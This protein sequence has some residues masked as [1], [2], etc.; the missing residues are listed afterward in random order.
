MGLINW[1]K[2]KVFYNEQMKVTKSFNYQFIF[3]A[4]KAVYLGS[5]GIESFYNNEIIIKKLMEFCCKTVVE[6]KKLRLDSRYLS[7]KYYKTKGTDG[8][9]AIVI[10]FPKPIEVECECNYVA[11]Y[12]SSNNISIYTSEYYSTDNKFQLCKTL[13]DG[14]RFS[15]STVTNT[16]K[17]FLVAIKQELV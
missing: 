12:E 9:R 1:R 14:S 2:N 4:L 17:D 15:Y 11:L 16:L 8:S 3:Y 5:N 13:D 6:N 10:E 7:L